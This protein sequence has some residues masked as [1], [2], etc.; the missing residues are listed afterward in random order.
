A[1]AALRKSY[2]SRKPAFGLIHHSDRGSPYA[3]DDYIAELEKYGMKRSMSN[4]GDCWDNAVAES[5]FSTLEFEC[6]RGVIYESHNALTLALSNYIEQFYNPKRMH[7]TLGYVSPIEA[8][9]S[10]NLKSQAA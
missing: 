6:V 9:L 10:F 4:K 8:E 1:L 2:Q 5:F 7:A 3:S